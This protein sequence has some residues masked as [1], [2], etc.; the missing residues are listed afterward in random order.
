MPGI[1]SIRE[2][3]YG[4]WE[5]ALEHV[6]DAGIHHLEVNVRPAAELEEI[7][8]AA[9]QKGVKIL[10]LSGGVNLDEEESVEAATQTIRMC[11]R[12]GAP[13]RFR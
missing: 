7:A 1:I 10:T 2:G 13:S 5:Q 4:G 3:G 9:G 11:E 6:T 8:R 12:L